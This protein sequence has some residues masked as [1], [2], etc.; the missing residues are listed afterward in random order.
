MTDLFRE[1]R[2]RVPALEAA[3]RYGME[4]DRAG[5][6]RCCFHSPDR[7]PSMSF[8]GSGFRCW[9][10]GS[11]GSAIDLVAQL[12]GLDALGAAARLND[13][14]SLGLPLHRKP[15]KADAAAAKRREALAETHTAFEDWRQE[16]IYRLCASF[17]AAHAR[18]LDMP[19]RLTDVEALAIRWAAE[20]EYLA[21]VLQS[22]TAAEQMTIFR[23]RQVISSRIGKILHHTK[24]KSGAA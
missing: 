19:D 3:R 8:K 16:T 2:E 1:V 15:T 14:F 6:A 10:C 22:G 12:C 5:R 11:H 13:D 9:S 7:H 20:A 24:T 4:L 23:E 18:L 21:D 17:Q